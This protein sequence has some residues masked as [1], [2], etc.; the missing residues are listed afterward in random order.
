[1]KRQ[2]TGFTLVELL[3]VIAIIGILI[4]LL[5]PA[6]QAARE[7]ARRMQ[8]SNNLKQI[9]V[10]LH[11]HHDTFKEFPE[12]LD[13]NGSRPITSWVRGILPFMEQQAVYD[14]FDMNQ[15]WWRPQ[16]QPVRA[17]KLTELRCPSDINAETHNT[18]YDFGYRGNYAANTGLGLYKRADDNPKSQ[19]LLT[20]AGPFAP[21]YSASFGKISDGSS[22]TVAISEIRKADGN[23]GRGAL[24]A[25]PGSVLYTHDYL[26]NEL[27]AD[28]TERCVSEEKAPC[29]PAGS[30]GYRLTARSDHPGGVNLLLFDGSV[31]FASETVSRP[32]W[33]AAATMSEGE[34]AQ[35]P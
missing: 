27:V 9:G 2:K 25:D 15:E 21:N 7:A 24:F 22:N 28:L 33:Q 29:S 19:T 31:R 1:M 6:V 3:V 26:P 30:S 16:N 5:L 12:G 8:C 10:S 13:F 32:V 20:I 18:A 35:L 14:L 23:D 11:N 17:V 4:A 34:V